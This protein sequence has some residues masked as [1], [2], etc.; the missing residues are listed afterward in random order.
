LAKSVSEGKYSQKG[1]ET[2]TRSHSSSIFPSIWRG[3]LVNKAVISCPYRC[4]PM[5]KKQRDNKF[6]IIAIF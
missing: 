1:L 4:I 3:V 5:K 2:A 6:L